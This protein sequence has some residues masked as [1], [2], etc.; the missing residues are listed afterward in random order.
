MHLAV[1]G[2]DLGRQRGGNESFI[3]GLLQ[4]FEQAGLPVE[5]TTLASPEGIR[6]L[7]TIG[8]RGRVV[9]IGAYRRLP[10]HL[11]QQSGILRKLH[12]DWYLSTYFLPPLLP[13]QGAVIVHDVSFRAHPE[14]FPPTI[15]CYM[16]ILTGQA[17][18]QARVVAYDSGYT[19]REVARYYP[20]SK[21][22]GIVTYPGV[23]LRFLQ[24]EDK[25]DEASVLAQ[26]KLRP[27]YILAIGNIHPRKN[28]ERLLDAYLALRDE[29]LHL[30]EMVWIG[31]PRW[32]SGA[33]VAKAVDCGV[34]LPGYVQ[35][36]HLPALY[37]AAAA[38]VYPSLYEG[39]G[40]PVLEAMASGTPVICSNTTSLPEAAGDA[41]LLVNPL[42][43]AALGS[44][45]RRLLNDFHLQQELAQRGYQQAA[46]FTYT[47]TARVLWQALNSATR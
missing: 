29:G 14:Y 12:P 43:T 8:Y 7:E 36:E 24:P 16:R 2:S 32:Q 47:D 44:A 38:F 39:F 5:L 40:L 10:F 30:P 27:G 34:R 9:D 22:K 19:A 26:L 35:S 41:A 33:L 31:L 46:R 17:I 42:D 37:R 11:W 25:R 18:R 6:M 45:L 3:L 1:N 21:D 28:L 20:E 15:S 4:G 23:N 13:C